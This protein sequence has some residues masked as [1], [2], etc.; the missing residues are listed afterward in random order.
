MNELSIPSQEQDKPTLRPMNMSD[1]VKVIK[2]IEEHDEDDG[3]AALDDY[4]QKGVGGQYIMLLEGAII[5]VTGAKE[6]ENSEKSCL[7]S[8]IAFLNDFE[9]GF[10]K[11]VFIIFL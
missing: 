2:I 7:A 5:G 8:L 11:R 4:S 10:E 9:H 6:I 1:L 3:E